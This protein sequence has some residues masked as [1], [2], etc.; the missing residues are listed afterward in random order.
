MP[1][2]IGMSTARYLRDVELGYLIR[3]M[4]EKDLNVVVVL[5]SCHSGGATRGAGGAVKRGIESIDITRRPA[6]SL[7]ADPSQLAAAWL[8][9]LRDGA[10]GT[11][12]LK[13]GSGWLLEPRGYTLL[14]A[15]RA[16]ESA[17][18]YPFDGVETRGALTYW[19]LD[20]LTQLGPGLS[21][22]VLHD[23]VL[24]KVHGQ[25]GSQT[26]QLEGEG[27]RQVFGWDRVQSPQAVAIMSVDMAKSRVLLNAAKLRPSERARDSPST[28]GVRPIS[29]APASGWRWWR[30]WNWK[31]PTP[32]R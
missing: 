22:K 19:L 8:D 13:P 3:Q 11:R 9:A 18:E 25:F 10:R 26:P 15:C 24:A 30:R 4:V 29:R 5:D 2:N 32:G 17:Y 1:T 7:V 20:A 23:R 16:Q 14:A 31:R 28:R 6:E 21:Y 27:D 12:A